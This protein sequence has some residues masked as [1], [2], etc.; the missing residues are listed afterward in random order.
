GGPLASSSALVGPLVLLAVARADDLEAAALRT[1]THDGAQAAFSTVETGIHWGGR[2]LS[3]LRILL[4]ASCHGWFARFNRHL[5]PAHGR[6]DH[7][8][9]HA[10]GRCSGGLHR[11]TRD[12]RSRRRL[13]NEREVGNGEHDTAGALGERRKRSRDADELP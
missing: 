7:H 5:E 2:S 4:D 3:V 9:L 11:I 13:R 8:P 6:L 1:E 12:T 10:Y